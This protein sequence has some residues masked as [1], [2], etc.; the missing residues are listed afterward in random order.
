MNCDT[1][2]TKQVVFGPDFPGD[3]FRVLKDRKIR[4]YVNTERAG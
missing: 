1:P 4:Q 3:T 2:R